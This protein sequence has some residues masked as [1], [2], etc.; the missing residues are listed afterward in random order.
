MLAILG[1]FCIW[2][3][4]AFKGQAG[5]SNETLWQSSRKDAVI[6]AGEQYK[7]KNRPRKPVRVPKTSCPAQNNK[8]AYCQEAYL[9]GF[10][11]PR[12]LSPA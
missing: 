6:L 5:I 8:Y 11:Y 3:S 4:L 10:F 9:S 7:T 2:P 1:A 12:N